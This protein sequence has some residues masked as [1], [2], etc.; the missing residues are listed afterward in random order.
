M[1]CRLPESEA[2]WIPDS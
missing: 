1:N 2:T